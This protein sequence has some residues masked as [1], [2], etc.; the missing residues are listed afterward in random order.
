MKLYFLRHANADWPEWTAS[1]DDRP[2]TRK[3]QKQS[4]RVGKLLHRMGVEPELI[5]TSPLPR[6]E[7][8]AEIAAHHLSLE[9]KEEPGLAKGFNL[10]ALR[11]II[12]RSKGVDLMVVGHEPSFSAVIEKLTGGRVKLAKAG[13]ACVELETPESDGTLLWLIP[14]KSARGS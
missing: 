3:G 7:Q 6:A 10:T 12:T 2:L 11:A 13:V 14:P 5:L 9:V 8:T 4:H 1:D